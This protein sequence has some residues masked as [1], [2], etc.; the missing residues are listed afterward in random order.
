[1]KKEDVALLKSEA[2][3]MKLAY[4]T[5]RAPGY[6]REASANGFE[7]FDTEGQKIT[8]E[9]ELKRLISLA[10]PPAWTNVWISPKAN[11]HLQATG[12]D[13]AGRKQRIEGVVQSS[14]S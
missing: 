5:D 14:R 12:I 7:Y 8:D 10:L 6:K 11:S 13:A 9:Q 1:M 4:I 2:R 3:A